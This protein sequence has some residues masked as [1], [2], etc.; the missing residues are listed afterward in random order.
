M[1]L[2]TVRRNSI[3]TGIF[4]EDEASRFVSQPLTL[5]R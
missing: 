3:P 4:N 5:A 1:Y 2:N